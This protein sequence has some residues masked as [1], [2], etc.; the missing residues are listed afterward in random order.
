MYLPKQ[1][2]AIKIFPNKV[3]DP[4]NKFISSQLEGENQIEKTLRSNG[5]RAESNI[6]GVRIE[7]DE[8]FDIT[9]NH[10]KEGI[11][12]KEINIEMIEKNYKID[13]KISE[14]PLHKF[15]LDLDK[16]HVDK[17]IIK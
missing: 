3:E 4:Y 5:E 7:N 16:A 2:L 17:V 6:D 13:R 14:C 11:D 15:H 9:P 8:N 10:L 12:D 1:P